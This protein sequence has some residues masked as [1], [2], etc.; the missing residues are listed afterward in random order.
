MPGEVPHCFLCQLF[1]SEDPAFA[2]GTIRAMSLV[3]TEQRGVRIVEGPEGESLMRVPQDVTLLLET[4][5]SVGSGA[6]LLHPEKVTPQFFDLS[7]GEAGEV[8]DKLRR[9]HVRLALVCPSG[10]ARFSSRFT[11]IF[12][13]DLQAFSSREEAC[14]WLASTSRNDDASPEQPS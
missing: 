1:E 3:V 11:E 12:A 4:C 10:T 13:D 6:V 9:F 14:L 8:L 7:S 5:L 2:G